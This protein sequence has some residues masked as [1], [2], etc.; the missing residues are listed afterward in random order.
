MM[1]LGIR[2]SIVMQTLDES[3]LLLSTQLHGEGFAIFHKY[4]E[5]KIAKRNCLRAQGF[6]ANT[7]AGLY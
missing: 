3:F 2:Q 5:R 1:N 4:G 7:C 6:L